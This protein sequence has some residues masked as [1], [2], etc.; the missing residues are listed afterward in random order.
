MSHVR[1]VLGLP[2]K[3]QGRIL[4]A[5]E[6]EVWTVEQMEREVATSRKEL[7]TGARR[8]R[9]PLPQEGGRKHVNVNN[10]AE[11]KGLEDH[12]RVVI[13][14]IPARYDLTMYLRMLRM[15]GEMDFPRGERGPRCCR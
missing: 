9:P 10:A 13:S 14:I 8:G 11:L 6:D 4:K 7:K 1:A 5:A 12:F 15:D 2:V 3:E